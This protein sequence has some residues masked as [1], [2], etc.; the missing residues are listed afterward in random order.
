MYSV[1]QWWKLLDSK[2]H[3]VA[4]KSGEILVWSVSVGAPGNVNKYRWDRSTCF[5]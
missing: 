3:K 2:N 5:K 1:C 4:L